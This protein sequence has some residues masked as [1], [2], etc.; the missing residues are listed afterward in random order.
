LAPSRRRRYA[1]GLL[2]VGDLT[3]RYP[4]IRLSCRHGAAPVGDVAVQETRNVGAVGFID[5]LPDRRL[6]LV[7]DHLHAGPRDV[8]AGQR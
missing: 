1:K 8:R 2:E 7:D 6:E 5:C 3:V 4:A